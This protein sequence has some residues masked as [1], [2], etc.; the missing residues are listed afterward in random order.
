MTSKEAERLI[1][2]D[3]LDNPTGTE[4]LTDYLTEVGTDAFTE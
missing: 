3:L 4:I 2:D 1:N